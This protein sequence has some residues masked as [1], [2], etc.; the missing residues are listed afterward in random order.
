MS[1]AMNTE[2]AARYLRCSVETVRR[3][4]RGIGCKGAPLPCL[5]FGPGQVYY[6]VDQIK[7]WARRCSPKRMRMIELS[8]EADRSFTAAGPMRL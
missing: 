3:Y 8:E 1:D 5:K 4:R 2:Q 7:D 6:E